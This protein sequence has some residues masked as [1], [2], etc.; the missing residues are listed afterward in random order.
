MLYEAQ[1]DLISS[2]TTCHATLNNVGVM[3]FKQDKAWNV[4]TKSLVYTVSHSESMH[5]QTM[6][7]PRH[8]MVTSY[9]V[10]NVPAFEKHIIIGQQF[11]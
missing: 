11:K 5:L 10:L 8:V 9:K 1:E 4:D 7:L 3:G 2:G 6:G